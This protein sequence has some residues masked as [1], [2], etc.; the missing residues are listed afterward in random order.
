MTKYW[1][2]ILWMPVPE[3][4]IKEYGIFVGDSLGGAVPVDPDLVGGD[5]CKDQLVTVTI[6]GL[7]SPVISVE[8][9]R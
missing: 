6:D 9:K 7:F 5:L 3:Q 4:G 1:G 8:P 2:K